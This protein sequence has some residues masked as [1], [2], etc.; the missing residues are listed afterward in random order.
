MSK[1]AALHPDPAPAPQRRVERAP[2]A[3]WLAYWP[4]LLVGVLAMA[5]S[6][7]L[8]A[9]R[10]SQ[11][12][13][14][15]QTQLHQDLSAIRTRLEA[16]AQ[17]TFSPTLGLEAMIQLDAGISSAR[18]EAL[19]G[20]VVKLL[21][22]VRSIV[23][24]PD[25]IA[26]YVYPTTG[27]QAVIDL[28]YRKIPAQYQQIQEAR[29]RGE[30]LLVGPVQLVQGGQ[31]IIQRTPVFLRAATAPAQ[32]ASAAPPNPTKPD[33][34]GKAAR[35]DPY[36]G[37]ISVVA[38]LDRFVSAAGLNEHPGLR[39]A[40]HQV[41]GESRVPAALIWGDAKLAQDA[42]SVTQYVQLPGAVWALSAAPKAS[43]PLGAAGGFRA[44]LPEITA[45][46]LSSLALALLAA[47][48]VY[49][50]RLLQAQNEALSKEVAQRAQSQAELQ[51]AQT[52]FRSLAEISAD[53]IWEQD[54]HLRFSF[55]S[56]M[57][58]EHGEHD[59]QRLLGRHRWDSPNL[60]PDIDW[61]AHR[62]VLARHEAFRDFEY[63]HLDDAGQMRFVSISGTPVFDAQGDFK[64]YRGTGRD[65]SAQ[66]R[67]EQA[68][69]SLNASL[70][71]R[72]EQRT[73]EL[74]H[75]LDT[76]KQAQTELLRAEKMAALGSLVAGIAHEL[77]T[78]LGNC[79]TTSS[80]LLDLTQQTRRHFEGGPMRRSMLEAYLKDADTACNILLRSMSSANE[81]VAHFKQV[82]VDQ[83]TAQRR[84]FS[85]ASV[86]DDVLSLLRQRLRKAGV[87]LDIEITV[88][89]E[90]DSFPGPL[91]QVLTNLVM[92]AMLH[93]F[94]DKLD[95]AVL[96]IRTEALSGCSDEREFLLI[97]ADN[98][99]GMSSEVKRRA[100]DPFF[101]TKMGQGGTGL[102]LNIVYNIVTGILGGQI[103]LQSEPQQGSRFSLR[104]PFEAPQ[105]S[106]S[107]DKL[108]G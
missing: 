79:L 98:G 58:D 86:V 28:D 25:D 100:F 8:L 82:S 23:A 106:S 53:W 63:S 36:W 13:A 27:N 101:T 60:S 77:N 46:L 10:Q 43:A 76:L 92:N 66:R 85:L 102:G 14:H 87:E 5:L 83:T 17:A 70:E 35:K 88:T 59:P 29:R 56:R 9:A 55:I 99:A 26:R 52:R 71:T 74:S 16:V 57:A 11:D 4:A 68:L 69:V 7:I 80:T 54:E 19:A 50:R 95:G 103:D 105:L 93:A 3:T 84:R 75:A 12:A 48:L 20:R 38:D 51:A 21:P 44:Y 108:G 49:R 67:A 96:S 41:Q 61:D 39:L 24:A 62:A 37:V 91:G 45:S 32:A 107:A 64:G 89:R 94:D 97:V 6:S 34:T 22:Q 2:L 73:A 18:F 42:T 1:A 81:L 40:L 33:E 78:P 104:L 15:A 72:V 90:L 47:L 65:I 30:P 31:G